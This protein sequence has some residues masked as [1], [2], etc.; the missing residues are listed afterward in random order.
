M[1]KEKVIRVESEFNG[2]K[3]SLETGK[4]AKQ[5]DSSVL[6]RLGDTTVLVTVVSTPVL[7]NPDYFPLKVDYEEKFYA[8][9]LIAGSRFTRREGRPN[10]EA[11]ISG[12]LIDH[13]M[14]PLFPKDFGNDTQIIVSVLSVDKK[15]CPALLGFLAGSAAFSTSGLPFSGPIVPIRIQKSDEKV[16][17]GLDMNDEKSSM[18]IIVSYLDDG[19]KVQAVEAEAEIVSEKE[20]LEAIKLGA[21]E[22]KPLFDLLN[23]FTKKCEVSTREYPKAWL[24]DEVIEKFSKDA[25]PLFE[26]VY[27]SMKEFD[28]FV[29][30][31]ELKK[32]KTDF[33]EKYADEYS[34]A[35]ITSIISEIEKKFVRNIVINKK[36][37]LDNRKFD[38]VRE[39]NA[40]I[41]VLPRVHGTGIFERGLTQSL[42][43]ATLAAPSEKLLIQS[44]NGEETKRYMHH[45]NF[46][47]FS[48]GEVGKVGTANRR[49]IGHGI[50]AE[51][52]L[53]PVLPDEDTFPYVI[54]TVSEILSSNGSTSMAATCASSLALMDAGVPIKS[55][56]AGIGVGLFVDKKNESP[57][58]E[59]FVLL[60]DI[61]GVEDFAGYMDFKMTG[62]RDGMTAIQ[63][64]LKLMGIPIDLLE[65]ILEVSKSARM[66]VLDVMDAA[67]KTPR[68]KISEYAPKID[69]VKIDKDL[70]G[71]VIGSGGATIKGITETTGAE[72]DIE[73]KEDHAIVSISSVSEDAIKAAKE[74]ILSIV[75]PI[76]E[77]D[78]VEGKVTRIEDYGVFVEIAPKKEGLIHVSEYAYGFTDNIANLV[79]LGDTI[80]AKVKGVENGKISLSKR[81]LEEKPEGYVEPERKPSNSGGFRRNDRNGSFGSDRR[82][83]RNRNRY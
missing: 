81:A 12:R 56:V 73:E 79:K 52:A 21:K 2:S 20:V 31:K 51:K 48:T 28:R 61:S 80:K 15:H 8:G 71:A 45:Y 18:E 65:S 63:M 57:K 43:I 1:N 24:T 46:P 64:E 62:T 26:K 35:Q 75:T 74:I 83:P 3:I 11:V 69:F 70:I 41:G 68:D 82:N 40:E 22:S 67:I 25:L 13:A 33:V 19:K 50:L 66:Q 16:K 49:A 17:A 30:Q 34:A 77:G 78:I 42:T 27:E 47:P 38:E 32:V 10:D 60:T 55:H 14:R 72:V 29:W 58:L 76:E 23:E 37:R 44:M 59:D 5:A 54:R 36:S 39:L 4:L 53:L 6:A 9:G 7:E